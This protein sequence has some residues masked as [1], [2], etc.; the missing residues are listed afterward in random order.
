MLEIELHGLNAR[1]KVLADIMWDLEE[2]EQVEAF[3]ATLPDREACECQTI[4]EMMRMELVEGYRRGMGLED[5]QEA[6]S[7]IQSVLDKHRG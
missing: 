3:I 2:Y 7:A 6:R 4:I 1:Q 5:T